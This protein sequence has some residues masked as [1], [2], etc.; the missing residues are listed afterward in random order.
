MF[1]KFISI[2]SLCKFI[3]L[4][5]LPEPNGGNL[6]KA[7][8]SE[9]LPEYINV[10]HA[11]DPKLNECVKKSIL[12]LRPY[13]SNGIPALSIP[14][15]DPLEIPKI[16]LQQDSGPINLNS[17]FENIKI[18]GLSHFRIRAVRIDP[19]KA[20][21]RLRLWFPELHMVADYYV[22]GKFLMVPMVGNGKSTGNFSDVDAIASLKAERFNRDGREFLRIKDIFAEFNIGHASVRLDSLFNG[23]QELS[24]TLNQF[25]NQ[26][27][28]AVTAEIKP[29]LEEFISNFLNETTSNLFNRYP[30]EQLLPSGV[31][32]SS[33][34][35]K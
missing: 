30:Y 32:A 11:N 23:N 16:S 20:K 27:W 6:I 5:L 26:N 9:R 10:C 12:N 8:Y 29:E 35:P 17:R 34:S 1:I 14:S 24:D 31:A 25:L 3:I 33:T 21:F 4:L 13:L 18:H 15:V 22:K 28:K 2:V 7:D 19:E